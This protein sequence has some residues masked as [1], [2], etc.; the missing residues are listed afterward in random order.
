MRKLATFLPMA[1]LL[2]IH[3]AP[4]RAG[5][6]VLEFGARCDGS[7]N[8]SA[9]FQ[10]ALDTRGLVSMPP[11]GFVC[12]ARNLIIR[13]D[14]TLD[15][16]SSTLSTGGVVTPPA[17][18]AVA[19]ELGSRNWAIVG[20][21][22]AGRI[23]GSKLPTLGFEIGVRVDGACP[24]ETDGNCRVLISGVIIEHFTTDALHIGGVGGTV[25]NGQSTHVRVVDSSFRDCGRNGVTTT[26]A[27][28]IRAERILVENVHGNPG[29][30]WDVEPN[31]HDRVK[32]L[33]IHDSVFRSS[34]IGLYMHPGLGLPGANYVIA[35][36]VIEDNAKIGLVGNS[37][38]GLYL[39]GNRITAP[40][41]VSGQPLPIAVTIGGATAAVLATDVVVAGNTA[42]GPTGLR[43]AGARNTTTTANVITGA[44]AVAVAL[45]QEG[46]VFA[47]GNT[48]PPA[49]LWARLRGDGSFKPW[50]SP[51]P[52]GVS[53]IHEEGR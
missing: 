46:T 52:W 4:A 50:T 30:A 2:A 6:S 37:I 17:T 24:D 28:N 44:K 43:Y 18:W 38:V 5:G 25:V 22:G 42:V 41:P 34:D 51:E 27:T 7:T 21:P 36:N 31:A 32:D 11:G 9:A 19:S 1:F 15:L 13:G 29:A 35:N 8:D 47:A 45:G 49:L 12:V 3:A 39:V 26:N 23:R 48:A 10:A 14:T 33:A 16:S 40:P 20:V 53:S